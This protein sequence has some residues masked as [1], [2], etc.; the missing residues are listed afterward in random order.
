MEA[1]LVEM[2]S[3]NRIECCRCKIKRPLP[4]ENFLA[5]LQVGVSP[6]RNRFEVRRVGNQLIAGGDVDSL[7]V[8]RDPAQATVATLTL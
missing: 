7:S 1:M 4:H 6:G 8:E 2:K 3:E 5:V